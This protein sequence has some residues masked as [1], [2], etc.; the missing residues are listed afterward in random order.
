MRRRWA[1]RAT[2]TKNRFC[3]AAGPRRVPRSFGETRA[4][5]PQMP[6]GTPSCLAHACVARDR[7]EVR[8][9]D[10]RACVAQ[11]PCARF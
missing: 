7:T 1:L 3:A 6:S 11:T 4:W 2:N 9:L 5:V 10:V 8:E